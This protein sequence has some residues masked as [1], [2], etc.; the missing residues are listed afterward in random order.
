MKKLLLVTCLIVLG[1]CTPIEVLAPPVDNLFISEANI[2]AEEAAYLGK[3]RKTYLKFCTR[4][5]SAR[6]VD[7]ITANN[8]KK[9]I[10]KMLKK[11]KL[12]PEEIK[13]LT[14]YLKASAKINQ[15]LIAR[16]K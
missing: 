2:S 3:G 5:H 15:K 12:Y 1:G 7:E 11:A 14:A 8:W 9:H 4:C 13:P 6:Q 10:P 16:R